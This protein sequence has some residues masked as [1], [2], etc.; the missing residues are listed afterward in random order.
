MNTIYYRPVGKAGP[1][2]KVRVTQ[3][4]RKCAGRRRA[5]PAQAD[6]QMDARGYVR[7]NT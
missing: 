6:R 1:I 4:K 2:V 3:R 5:Y 7:V